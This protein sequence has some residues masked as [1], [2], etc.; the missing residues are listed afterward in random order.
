[1]L[2]II[3]WLL[4]LTVLLLFILFKTEFYANIYY[5][6]PAKDGI[7]GRRKKYYKD[8]SSVIFEWTSSRAIRLL[9]W[10]WII[11]SVTNK[12]PYP[13]QIEGIKRLLELDGNALLEENYDNK[14][15]KRGK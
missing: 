11:R 12:K 2:I 9:K 1:M 10:P 8:S 4:I 3:I 14:R 13:F 15:T 5:L 6:F 7:W